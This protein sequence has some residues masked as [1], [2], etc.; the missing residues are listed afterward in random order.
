MRK[1]DDPTPVEL[2]DKFHIGSCTK[3]MTALL[4]VL[5]AKHGAIRLEDKAGGIFPAWDEKL[6]HI[7]LEMLLRHRSGIGNK[8]PEGLWDRAFSGLPGS[9]MEQRQL[10]LKE[11]FEQATFEPP[12]TK[13]IYSNFGFALAG[14]MLEKK[15][16]KPWEELMRAKIFEP[17]GMDS[18]G[19]GPPTTADKVNQPWGHRKK[20]GKVKAMDPADN[21]VVIGPAGTVHCSILDLARYAAF[22][23][24]AAQGLVPELKPYQSFL[25]SAPEG[26]DYAAGWI[27]GERE[28]AGGKILTHSGSNT[29]FYSVIWIVPAKGYAM[30]LSANIGDRGDETWTACDGIISALIKNYISK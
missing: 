17:L 28:W 14:A 21:P 29:M 19:F 2:S 4:A 18:A 22:H 8:P 3:S 12:N 1:I 25:Y 9:P 30:V 15:A 26:E 27:V 16:G 7:T 5:L 10:F 24:Q 13:H 11:L 20:E 6:D 23:L